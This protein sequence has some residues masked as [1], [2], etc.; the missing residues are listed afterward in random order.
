[1]NTLDIAIVLTYFVLMLGLGIYSSRDQNTMEDFYLGGKGMGTISMMSLW[2]SSWIGGAAII[3]TA[4]NAYQMGITA[5][6]YIW[7]MCIGFAVFGL[8]F[9]PIIKEAGDKFN[10]ITYSDLIED[11]YDS[12]CRIMS[13]ITTILANIAYN[14]GQ[15]VAAGSL[16]SMFTGWNLAFTILLSA[17]VV[18]IYT[19]IG[20][21]TA[22]TYTDLIQTGLIVF[23][24]II[25]V[26]FVYNA[27]NI[28]STSLRL[29]LP[30]NYFNILEWGIPTILGFIVT[31]TL[32]FFT[33]MDSYTR[34][35]AAKDVKTAQK[36]TLLAIIGTGIIAVVTTYLGMAGKVIFPSMG[37]ADSVIYKLILEVLPH[38][39][40]GLMLIGLISALMSTSSISILSS[41]AN[42]TRDIYQRYLNPSA[43]DKTLKKISVL[44]S[45][46]IGILSALL[47]IR[48]ENIINILYIAFTI[49]SVGL[50]LPTIS[51]FFWKKSNSNATFWSMGISLI[52]VLVWFFGNMFS[53]IGIFKLDPVW[54]GLIVAAITFIPLSLNHKD[55]LEDIEKAN[56]YYIER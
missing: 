52:V 26:P 31:I 33:S 16:I 3:G 2:L 5:V 35:F 43:K 8:F 28:G 38:G 4:D 6:W 51:I 49:N 50:F 39:V 23:S 55:T 15:L 1:M 45:L 30:G 13:I 7:S 42:I 46:V 19:S 24:L 22:V 37:Q 36:G 32:T 41:S 20:G 54:P 48:M 29:A 25:A 56:K 53:N 17:A 12:K 40:K 34:C 14:A 21:L 44:S 10:H 18:T 27:S 9:T 11:R 47:A